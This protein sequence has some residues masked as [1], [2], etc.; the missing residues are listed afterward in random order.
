MQLLINF[1]DDL[2]NVFVF[3]GKKLQ[4]NKYYLNKEYLKNLEKSTYTAYEEKKNEPSGVINDKGVCYMNAL[5]QCF[6]HCPPLKEGFIQLNDSYL[7]TLSKGFK[8]LV[9]ELDKG[10]LYAAKQFKKAMFEVDNSFSSNGGKD[11]KD[12]AILMLCEMHYEL[13]GNENSF[14]DNKNDTKDIFKEAFDEL[15]NNSTIISNTFHY[16]V[17]YEKK[18]NNYYNQECKYK[19]EIFNIDTE[20]ILVFEL[21]KIY[22]D[23]N[24]KNN[25]PQN[26]QISIIQCFENYFQKVEIIKCPNCGTNSLNYNKFIYYLPEIFIFVMNQGK[27]SKY[28]WEIFCKKE[29][30]MSS[31]YCPKYNN[32]EHNLK[33]E[34]I[35]GTFINKYHTVALCQAYNN[36]YYLFDDSTTIK[37]NSNEIKNSNYVFSFIDNKAPYILFYRKIEENNI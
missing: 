28:N 29:I 36:D 8:H 26:P 21:E 1:S 15:K 22:K 7:G 37:I 27:N 2:G 31:Y 18:C 34:F 16:L 6:Y 9:L 35:C 3:D 33:Y 19:N 24:F 11:S 4:I 30:D 17:L 12:L 5:L 32:K 25:L 10:N 20:N 14:I 23:I 13:K